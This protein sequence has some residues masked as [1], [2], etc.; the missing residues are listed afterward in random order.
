M[1]HSVVIVESKNDKFFFD[2]II[3]HLNFNS[4]ADSI[5]ISKDD[6]REM[7]GNDIKTALKDLKADVPKGEVE[8]IGLLIDG[9][10]GSVVETVLDDTFCFS[11]IR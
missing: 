2:A 11:C 1:G 10:S 3:R 5:P 7:N 8:K 6:Y 9:S 4:K